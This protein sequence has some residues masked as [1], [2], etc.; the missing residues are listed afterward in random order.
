MLARMI[1]IDYLNC[2]RKMQTGKIP[3][4][5]G[6]VAQHD[7]LC[8]ATCPALTGFEVDSFTKLLGGLDSAGV[9]GGVRIANGEALFVELGLSENASQF[10]LPR[11]GWLTVRLA[12]AAH[13]FLLDH[14]HSGAIHLDVENRNRLAC[15][16]RQIQL[17][18]FLDFFSRALSYIF[19]DSF[20]RA[21]NRLSRHVQA[22]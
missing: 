1:E 3:D 2:A 9:S 12:Q 18:R 10:D 8:R 16:D 13:R 21:L 20:R 15:D 14:R 19:S 4:P 6:A 11:M 7:F 22:G 17:D 5:F